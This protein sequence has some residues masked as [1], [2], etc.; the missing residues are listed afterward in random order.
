VHLIMRLAP[1]LLSA[2]MPLFVET[3]A[4]STARVATLT[5]I[6]TGANAIGGAIGGRQFGELGDRVGH[7][8]ILAICALLSTLFYVPQ[9][10]VG[11]SIWLIPLQ[12]G[13][14]LAMGGIMASIS[15]SLAALSPRGREGLVYGVDATVVS[16]ANAIGPMTGS[17][18]AVWLGLRAPF[19]AAAVIF[20]LAG[21]AALQFLPKPATAPS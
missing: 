4:P 13:A 16:I 21:I 20:V 15:A 1:R 18:M 7:R 19:L 12:A 9:S 17:S 14:G 10:M 11:R 2:I 3:V 5:G 6:I 8:S